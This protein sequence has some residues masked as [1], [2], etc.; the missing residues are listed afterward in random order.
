MSG[1]ALPRYE[2]CGAC[3]RVLL[4]VAGELVCCVRDCPE[5]GKRQ[6]RAGDRGGEQG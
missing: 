4:I 6:D 3:G 5:Y 2:H 1:S